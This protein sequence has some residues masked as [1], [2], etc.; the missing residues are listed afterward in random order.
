MTWYIW[1]FI[2]AVLISTIGLLRSK[3]GTKA[4]F[5]WA[6]AMVAFFIGAIVTGVFL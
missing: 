5:F 2:A 3:G 1:A 6:V 4:E